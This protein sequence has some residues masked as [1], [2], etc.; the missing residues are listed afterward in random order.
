MGTPPTPPRSNRVC[1]SLL[2][3]A[4]P[5]C[6]TMFLT[7][8]HVYGRSG[9]AIHFDSLVCMRGLIRWAIAGLVSLA[10]A[11]VSFPSA[12]QAPD[13]FRWT[14]FHPQD[15]QDVVIWVTRALDG[16]KW[17]A[18]REIGVQY[19]AALVITSD[20]ASNKASPNHDTF[21]I[22][23]VSLA[24]RALTH[25]LDGVN[26]RL[27]DWLMLDLGQARELGL[28]YDDCND[29]QAT[30]YFT[31][32]RYDLATHTFAGRW[33]KAGNGVPVWKT[34]TSTG[35]TQTQVYAVMADENGRETLGTWN[36]LDY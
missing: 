36:H 1:S 31:T 19:D 2:V 12:A 11:C 15:D 23:S 20:R 29:C 30:T 14:D 32:L 5:P 7:Q 8:D 18:I 25:V 24:N 16:Q 27:T 6:K 4:V 28:L 13:S 33:M 9:T 21:S 10:M 34:N 35:V 17:T 3:G 26:L 22:W